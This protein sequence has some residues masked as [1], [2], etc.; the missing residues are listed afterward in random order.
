MVLDTS[1]LI[2][3]IQSEPGSDKLISKIEQADS[4][5]ISAATFVEAGIVM[6]SRY[7]D[8]GVL[9]VDQFIHRLGIKVIPVTD[10]QA[11]IALTAYCKYGMGR[12]P[13]GLNYGDCFSYA[14]ASSLREPLL[15]IG[16]DF[17]RTDAISPFSQA[18]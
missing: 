6:S 3:I 4:L 15:Y 10:D 13:A 7:G 8:P 2:A 5:K 11:V 14:L 16:E 1:A 12:H 17:N 9:E 18:G